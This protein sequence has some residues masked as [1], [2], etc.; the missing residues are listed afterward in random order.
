MSRIITAGLDGSRESLAAA[1]WAARES[2]LR[3]LPCRLVHAWELQSYN[4]P[5]ASPTGTRPGSGGLLQGGEH[6]RPH[7]TDPAPL[8]QLSLST[9]APRLSPAPPGAPELRPV[10]DSA[11]P[12]D[13]RPTPAGP[14]CA[15]SP[16]PA[17][18]PPCPRSGAAPPIQQPPPSAQ[19]PAPR[20]APRSTPPSPS[21]GHPPD[22]EE[23][24][25]PHRAR[26]ATAPPPPG[27]PSAW[28]PEDRSPTAPGTCTTQTSGRNPAISP[29]V[30]QNPCP[31]SPNQTVMFGKR[32]TPEGR[33]LG[34][35]R[36]RPPG[37]RRRPTGHLPA[38]RHLRSTREAPLRFKLRATSP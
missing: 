17:R 13:R 7:L 18:M 8:R 12:P 29:T 22:A 19:T 36:E 23:H 24:V 25:P 21:P 15:G 2:L 32:M 16:L 26:H 31:P 34:C 27:S 33:N 1:D 9:A 6:S 20:Q 14:R 35:S 10:A 11:C 37:T 30:N 5:T 3:D 4:Y 38:V 28:P